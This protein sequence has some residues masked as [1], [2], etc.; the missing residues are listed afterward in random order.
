M[1]VYIL[2]A[3]NLAL[4]AVILVLQ[5]L[6]RDSS[7]ITEKMDAIASSLEGFERYLRD[8]LQRLRNDLLG[9]GSELRG[10]LNASIGRLSESTANENRLNREET[11]NSLAKL[12]TQINADALRNREELTAAQNNLSES[13]S[14]RLQ[15]LTSTQQSQFDLLKASVEQKMEQI[16]SLNEAKLEQMR[17]TVDEKLH[18]TLEKRLGDSFQLVSQRLELV[19]RGLG[20]MQ[21]LATGV[22]DLKKALTNVKTRGVLGEYQLE[23]ILEDLFSPEFYER[24]FK[25]HKRRDE[26]VEFALKL[27]GRDDIDQHVYLPIDAKFPIEDYQ[28]LLDAYELGDAG[29]VESG[30]K[31]L[32]ARIKGCARDIRDKYLNPPLT[33]DF[34]ILFLPFEGL[35]AEVLRNPGLFESVMREYSV[36][37]SGPTTIAALLNSLQ[38]GFRT[39]AI[40]KKSSEVWKLLGAIKRDFSNFGEILD[41]TKR[42]I[43]DAGRELDNASHR[44]RQIEKKLTRVQELPSPETTEILELEGEE[45]LPES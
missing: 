44:S 24:N 31:N 1:L 38:V 29:A 45:N 28:R 8:D 16:R 18:E 23:N 34:A 37:I 7:P 12:G 10:E 40:H 14:R 27:P 11:T 2:L 3:L 20:E 22:G 5:L 33:T 26:M 25:P 15:E 17:K 9:I 6:R 32:V 43:E 36:I 13:L 35:Y 19:H 42:K 4:A 39:L 21:A 41:K 30:R